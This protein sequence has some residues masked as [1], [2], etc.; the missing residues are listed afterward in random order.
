MTALSDRFGP[1]DGIWLSTAHQGALPRAAVEAAHQALSWK[2]SPN[3]LNE[4]SYGAVIG[5]LKQALG[6]L[7]NAPAEDIILGNSASYGMHLFA[8]GLP[9]NSG[10]EV[11]LVDGDFPATIYA[12][13]PLERH[14]VKPRFIKPAGA[15][16]T[17]EEVADQITPQTRVF[18]TNWVNS[19]TG[20]A[21]PMEAIGAVC[22]ERDVTFI[23]NIFQ[24]VGARPIDLAT[25]PVDGVT[26]P[27]N[28]RNE[29][30][31]TSEPIQQ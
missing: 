29:Q 6:G 8:N 19:F 12:W 26:G 28:T 3:R 31:R 21:A 23:L 7:V 11:L 15:V 25:A 20:C 10:D 14:G 2:I 4:D 17:A 24:A 18:C 27:T 16:V 9:L 13:L 1:F 22:R 5:G 30:T